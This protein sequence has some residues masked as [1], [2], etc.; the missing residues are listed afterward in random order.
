[1]KNTNPE[2]KRVL[3]DVKQEAGLPAGELPSSEGT[4][5]YDVVDDMHETHLI[6]TPQKFGMLTKLISKY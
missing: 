6:I 5:W 2:R 4:A 3:R 1:M